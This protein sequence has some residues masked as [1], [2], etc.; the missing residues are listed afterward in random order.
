MTKVK[1]LHLISS[2]GMYG[3]ERVI[4]SWMKNCRNITSSI[5]V[6]GHKSSS[7][8]PLFETAVSEGFC[9]KKIIM[10]RFAIWRSFKA[11]LIFV[12]NKNPDIIH[13][14]G[15]KGLFYGRVLSWVTNKKLVHTNHG[16]INNSIKSK[17][18]NHIELLISRF[19]PPD[20]AL[21][22]SKNIENK[23]LTFGVSG[24]K[25]KVLA[26]AIQPN[27]NYIPYLFP[28]ELKDKTFDKR[29]IVYVGRLS[30]EKGIDLFIEAIP[31]ICDR[32]QDTVFFIVGDGPM[33]DML[34]NKISKLNIKD[35]I[36]FTGFRNDAHSI[37][38]H[39][40]V[41]VLPSRTEGT[42][43]VL[44]EAMSFAKPVVAFKVGGVPDVI[45]DKKDGLIISPGDSIAFGKAICNLL[46]DIKLSS[47][48]GINARKTVLQKFNLKNN[49]EKLNRLYLTLCIDMTKKTAFKTATQCAERSDTNI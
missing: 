44:L 2:S 39:S 3:A 8:N 9:A 45:T 38:A 29:I 23:F 30:F 11:A 14:H 4:L 48:L 42:P 33:K 40:D 10:G 13:S 15:Y 46:G 26:N 16:F 27:L 28:P 34:Q 35:R 19:F 41:L 22:V 24:K 21:L 25:I 32:F 1:V 37:I 5:V 36:I 12:R 49:I 18:N 6:F 20:L 17:I 31:I 47:R 43:I 7:Q